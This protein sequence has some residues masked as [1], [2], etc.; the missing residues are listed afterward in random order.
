[1]G[2]KVAVIA[3]VHGNSSAL[4]SV[5][6]DIDKDSEIQHIY[7]VGDM[8]GIGHETNEVLELL[9]S[10][11]DISFVMGNHEEEFIAILEGRESRSMGG[12]KEHHEW[13]VSRMDK[14]F[15]SKL[16]ELP[17]KIMAE[18]EGKKILFIHYHLDSKNQFLTIDN[19]PSVI[20]LDD[21]YIDSP[22]NM[23]CFGH[24]HPLHFYKSDQ[25][26]YLNPGSLGCYDKPFARYA[27]L[28]IAAN[29]DVELKEIPYNNRDFLLAYEDLNVPVKDFIL[30]VFHGDQH[31]FLE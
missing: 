9:F 31:L 18:H 5:L 25:R 17:K 30:K 16:K 28:N 13:L 7:C 20:K 3:D 21:L 11:H 22:V 12:E 6:D 29:I 14:K 4:R 26:L 2:T 24:H 8:V 1:M 23:V 19:A 27:V 15:T 10:R